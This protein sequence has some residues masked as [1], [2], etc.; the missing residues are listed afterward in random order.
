MVGDVTFELLYGYDTLVAN[1]VAQLIPHCRRGFGDTA[2]A[3]GVL[4]A[5]GRLVAGVVYH[6]YDPEAQIMEMSGASIDPRWMTRR[7]V[8]STF[9]Y[10]FL[11]CGCQMVVMRLPAD[12]ERMLRQCAV[13]N[14]VFT[15][16][17]RLFGRDRD[18]VVATLTF[19]DWAANKFNK[20]FKWHIDNRLIYAPEYTEEAA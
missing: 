4:D 16:L 5:D 17:P 13:F 9:Q 20:R 2:K 14:F 3:I 10:P 7:V 19:E 6:N 1:F 11:Q 8:G 18:G 12:N 15:E